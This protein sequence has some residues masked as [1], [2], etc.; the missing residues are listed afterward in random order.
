M[1]HYYLRLVVAAYYYHDHYCH[2]QGDCIEQADMSG[3]DYTRVEHEKCVQNVGSKT[4][5]EETIW[6]IY[7]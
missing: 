5:K 3:G 4:S 1:T 7:A 6:E 2:R